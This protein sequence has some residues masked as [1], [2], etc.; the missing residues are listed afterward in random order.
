MRVSVAIESVSDMVSV[1]V[2]QEIA[3]SEQEAK[4]LL[5]QAEGRVDGFVGGRVYP[6]ARP[7]QKTW[8]VQTYYTDDGGRP[9]QGM[10][11]LKVPANKATKE[12]YG[13]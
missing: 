8:V 10:A 3:R 12:A 5:S 1:F 13:L 4:A 2:C 7:R 9:P 11:R 6:P